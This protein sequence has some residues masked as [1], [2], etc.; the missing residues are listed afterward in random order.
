M[1]ERQ[2]FSKNERLKSKRLFQ[3]V[4]TQGRMIYDGCALLY[5]LPGEEGE[6]RLGLAVGKRLGSAVVLNRT[7]RLMREVFRRHKEELNESCDYVWLA[8]RPLIGAGLIMTEKVFLRLAKK[9]AAGEKKKE[10]CKSC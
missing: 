4:C 7:K 1:D 8:R 5:I 2:T 9:A 3:K 6:R 10:S